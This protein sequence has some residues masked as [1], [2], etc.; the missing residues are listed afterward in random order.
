MDLLYHRY[1]S[2]F[3]LLDTV[4]EC[5]GFSRFI[6]DFLD[7]ADKAECW[8]YFLHKVFDKSYNEFIDGL[9]P[10]PQMTVREI[11]TKIQDAYKVQWE[12][13]DIGLI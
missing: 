9:K 3:V 12:V 10:Q 13:S 1:A 4:I 2:P 7:F 8:E 5:G 6:D 11:E